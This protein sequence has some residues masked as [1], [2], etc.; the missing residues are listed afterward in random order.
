M[1]ALEGYVPIFHGCYVTLGSWCGVL[2]DW[3]EVVAWEKIRDDGDELLSASNLPDCNGVECGFDVFG[4]YLEGT[5]EY[6][7]MI[8]CDNATLEAG[9][10]K[11]RELLPVNEGFISSLINHVRIPLLDDRKDP[12]CWWMDLMV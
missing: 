8:T 7:G 4:L 9:G 3:C 5:E 6:L 10:V 11:I 12:I 1:V 2:R